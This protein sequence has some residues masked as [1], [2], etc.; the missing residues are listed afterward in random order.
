MEHRVPELVSWAAGRVTL[1]SGD[2]IACGT[3]HEGLGPVQDGE[4]LTLAIGDLGSLVVTVRDP[5]R[6]RWDRGVYMGRDSTNRAAVE[7]LKREAQ[8][9]STS[10]A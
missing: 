5:L 4:T 7:R 9:Q 10:E 2:M 6:R 1:R 3:N 8:R